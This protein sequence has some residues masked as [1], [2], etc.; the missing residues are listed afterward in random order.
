MIGYICGYYRYYYPVEF[1]TAY[2]NNSDKEEDILM[3]TQLAQTLGVTIKPPK[4]RHSKYN[5][6]PDV[7]NKTIY[8][9]I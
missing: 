6:F 4:F 2:L 8:I 1:T 9:C 3:G 7:E 5:Y